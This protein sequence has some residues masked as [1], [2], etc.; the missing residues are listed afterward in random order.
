M[1]YVVIILI[2]SSCWSVQL[3]LQLQYKKNN[4]ITQQHYNNLLATTY[5]VVLS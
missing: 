2:C 5:E 3:Q 4:F 1:L